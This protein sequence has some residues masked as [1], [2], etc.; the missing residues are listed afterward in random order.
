MEEERENALEE[1]FDA[2]L[3]DG[4]RN[5]ATD[6]A[7]AEGVIGCLVEPVVCSFLFPQVESAAATRTTSETVVAS[8]RLF[9]AIE[10]AE[11]AQKQ[12]EQHRERCVTAKRTAEA[13]GKLYEE[14]SR[15]EPN[16]LL[17][18]KSGP[19]YLLDVL[20]GTRAAMLEHSLFLL[21]FASA[22]FLLRH[23]KTWLENGTQVE[24]CCKALFF[25]LRLHHRQLMIGERGVCVCRL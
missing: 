20:S 24:L 22:L 17:L 9:E 23:I 12:E 7:P 21:P 4:G 18:G 2:N 11:E 19:D 15:P 13:L 10:L 6:G 14:P 16:V 8:E 1:L 5:M 3:D 25:V